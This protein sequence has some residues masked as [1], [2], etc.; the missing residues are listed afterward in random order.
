MEEIENDRTFAKTLVPIDSVAIDKS[1]SILLQA[2]EE[3]HLTLHVETPQSCSD[4]KGLSPSFV[5]GLEKLV[6]SIYSSGDEDMRLL[7]VRDAQGKPAGFI[8]WRNLDK[9]EMSEWIKPE[10]QHSPRGENVLQ[11]SRDPSKKEF[12]HVLSLSTGTEKEEEVATEGWIKIELMCV[13]QAMQGQHIGTILLAA[14]LFYS[15]FQ[16]SKTH[17]LL[18]VA[19]GTK[20]SRAVALYKK[21][22]FN[23]AEQYFEVP[24]DNI[25]VLWEIKRMIE[26]FRNWNELTL[27][28]SQVPTIE[29]RTG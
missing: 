24:N 7:S 22:Q 21:F 23:W 29:G 4:L 8:F 17:A 16:E 15:Y 9:Q 14:A 2:L 5:S 13:S 1:Q 27:S 10:Y 26:A 11:N 12:A 28:S 20:N 19:G 25:M 6:I 3:K 18:Q